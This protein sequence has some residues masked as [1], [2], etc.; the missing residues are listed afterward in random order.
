MTPDVL[1][2]VDSNYDTRYYLVYISQPP[3]NL[4]ASPIQA[5]GGV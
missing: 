2:L 5:L 4:H 3:R 1:L